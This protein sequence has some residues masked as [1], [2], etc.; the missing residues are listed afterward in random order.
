M[1]EDLDHTPTFDEIDAANLIVG[2]GSETNPW[3]VEFSL[4]ESVFEGADFDDRDT[5]VQSSIRQILY[6][7][8]EA[9]FSLIEHDAT[10]DPSL[11]VKPYCAE[12]MRSSK[13]PR[14]E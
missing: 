7:T 14:P 2:D 8:S 13:S 9:G 4:V 5:L 1:N 11:P 6:R 12:S 10:S 3:I